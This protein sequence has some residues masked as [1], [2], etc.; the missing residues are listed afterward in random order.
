MW[1]YLK[2]NIA[3]ENGQARKTPASEKQIK[4]LKYLG[5]TFNKWISVYK[6]KYL[7]SRTLKKKSKTKKNLY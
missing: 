6:A 7:I 2:S 3:C 1:V 5:V 4:Y